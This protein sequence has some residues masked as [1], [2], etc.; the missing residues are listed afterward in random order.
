MSFISAAVIH[1]FVWGLLFSSELSV[2]CLFES[3][4]IWLPG[5][6]NGIEIC[7]LRLV[8]HILIHVSIHVVFPCR[9]RSVTRKD[10]PMKS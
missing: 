2:I 8:F 3:A 4:V 7:L 5:K 10:Q 9:L 6:K 1:G